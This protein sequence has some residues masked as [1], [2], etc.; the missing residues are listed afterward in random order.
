MNRNLSLHPSSKESDFFMCSAHQTK[1]AQSGILLGQSSTL[2]SYQELWQ[3]RQLQ[4]PPSPVRSHKLLRCIRTPTTRHFYTGSAT[5]IHLCHPASL[6]S[7]AAQPI[8]CV[9]YYGRDSTRQGIQPPITGPVW[10]NPN[11]YTPIESEHHLRLGDTALNH[12]WQYIL[13]WGSV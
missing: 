6:I 9:G 12:R 4:F 11:L 5:N 13:F 3:R 8:K 1:K 2:Q 7:F 10:S